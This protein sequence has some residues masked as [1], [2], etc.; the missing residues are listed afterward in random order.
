M[1]KQ[2]VILDKNE[3]RLIINLCDEFKTSQIIYD[4]TSDEK[5]TIGEINKSKRNSETAEIKDL[6]KIKEF[7]LPRL[8][9]FNIKDLPDNTRVL[10]YTK[11][12]FFK[13]HTDRVGLFGN[14][15]LTLIIQ[16]SDEQ[17]YDGGVLIVDGN[18]ISKQI[19]NL[20]LFD[21]GVTHEVTELNN[22]ERFA[23]VA[24]IELENIETNS[25]KLF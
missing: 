17:S 20:I 7:L 2:K 14:R 6:E 21:S 16:L 9:E 5:E 15:K 3:C 25:H 24:W 1:F 13:P 8:K 19:G 22:G 11:G 10:K 12:S 4:N 23:L 18:P